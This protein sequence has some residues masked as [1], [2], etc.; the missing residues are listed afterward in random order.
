MQRA[1]GARARCASSDPSQLRSNHPEWI[2]P[3]DVSL[4]PCSAA[5]GLWARPSLLNQK[6]QVVYP[7]VFTNPARIDDMGQIVFGV[8]DNKIGVRNRIVAAAG[9]CFAGQRNPR[10]LLDRLESSFGSRETDKMSVEIV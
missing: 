9:R 6:R 10:G 2:G 4:L 7:I 8:C 1:L 3:R 5:I